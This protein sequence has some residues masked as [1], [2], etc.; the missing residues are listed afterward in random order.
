[1]T[2]QKLSYYGTAKKLGGGGMGVIYKAGD[3]SLVYTGFTVTAP[4]LAADARAGTIV[5]WGCRFFLAPECL[6]DL[7]VTHKSTFHCDGRL[8]P[9]DPELPSRDI[10]STTEPPPSRIQPA[11]TFT[12]KR[13][14][15]A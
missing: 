1:L 6:N 11:D 9:R 8:H 2:G 3:I 14:F 15:S 13:L 12:T 4:H 5:R 10:S 7:P